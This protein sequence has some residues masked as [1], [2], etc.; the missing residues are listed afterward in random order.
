M[1]KP[2]LEQDAVDQPRV[3]LHAPRV[4][5]VVTVLVLAGFL[6]GM[7]AWVLLS[8][9]PD[10]LLRALDRPDLA[11]SAW[12]YRWWVAP[13][14]SPRARASTTAWPPKRFAARVGL[15]CLVAILGTAAVWSTAPV[16][17]VLALIMAALATLEAALGFCVACRFYTLLGWFGLVEPCAGGRCDHPA[18]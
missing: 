4:G 17:V 9:A 6:A 7:P 1:T 12:L 13:L 11:P 3:P 14:L 8:L 2:E 18:R 10:F 5:A 15:G 16:A